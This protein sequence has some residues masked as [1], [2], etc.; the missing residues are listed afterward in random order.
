M[1]VFFFGL[2]IGWENGANG[3]SIITTVGLACLGFA[4]GDVVHGY[5]RAD[6]RRQQ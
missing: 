5:L 6:T 3:I 1:L 2:L 4:L